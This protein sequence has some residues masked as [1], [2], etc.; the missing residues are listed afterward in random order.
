MLRRVTT[1]RRRCC[2]EAGRPVRLAM[3]LTWTTTGTS[4]Y[5]Y[6]ITTRYGS[7]HP[8]PGTITVDG[9]SYEI[10]AAVGQRDHSHGVR[11]WWSMDW[12]WSALH[13]DDDTH[14]HGST[15]ASPTCRR[16]VSATSSAGTWSRRRRCP[17]MRRSRTTVARAD[18]DRLPARA[19]GHHDRVV[20]NAPVRLVAPDGRVSLFPRAWVE[21]ETTDGRRGVGWAEWNRN[22]LTTGAPS[23]RPTRRGAGPSVA[24]GRSP[25]HHQAGGQR[26]SATNSRSTSSSARSRSA[27][28]AIASV[29]FSMRSLWPG[30]SR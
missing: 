11:D 26:V 14:L 16:S 12:V 6:R 8:P 28:S 10:E 22:P 15:Y 3:D 4:P 29:Q 1:T 9:R 30:R 21:V 2:G 18:P 20:G 17:R 27:V 23:R 13:L 7:L 25:Y 24:A 19:G 5:A